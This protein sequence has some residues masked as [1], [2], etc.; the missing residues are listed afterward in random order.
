MQRVYKLTQLAFILFCGTL[1]AQAQKAHKISVSV[2]CT[3]DDA[4][5][6]AYAV[7]VHQALSGN[8]HYQEV[9]VSE[10][11]EHN[12]I[13]VNII[14]MPIGNAE[15]KPQSAL[16]IVCLHNGVIMHQFIETCTH[17]P[18]GECAASMVHDL[19]TWDAE[20]AE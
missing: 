18:I 6:Q 4:T 14:S 12:A 5:G 1:F 13:R 20:S 7:A 9:G 11:M 17:I 8:S 3:C 16:S 10:G 19:L 2:T 15:D